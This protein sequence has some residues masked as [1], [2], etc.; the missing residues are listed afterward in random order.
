MVGRDNMHNRN[1]I[2]YLEA[3]YQAG[4]TTLSKKL[5][6]ALTKD[7]NDQLNYYRY[8]KESKPVY[9]NGDLM[10]DEQFCLTALQHIQAVDQ[11][12]NPAPATIPER[13]GQQQAA[14]SL[15]K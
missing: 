8:L 12:Y 5:K 10:S 2:V 1:T 11:Q 14:D 9:Y 4:H 6:D 7:L 3:A 15:P 13:P